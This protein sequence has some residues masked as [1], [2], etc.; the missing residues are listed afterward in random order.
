MPKLFLTSTHKTQHRRS[1]MCRKCGD[2]SV[3]SFCFTNRLKTA[4]TYWD[5]SLFNGFHRATVIAVVC[6]PTESAILT[7][8]DATIAPVYQ[9]VMQYRTVVNERCCCNDVVVFV[10]RQGKLSTN[11]RRFLGWDWCRREPVGYTA[12]ICIS[13]WQTSIQVSYTSYAS[14][15]IRRSVWENTDNLFGNAIAATRMT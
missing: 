13:R 9:H 1:I 11:I 15:H 8:R 12:Y 3:R 7:V 5:V 14:S 2:D 10:L 4:H 6:K